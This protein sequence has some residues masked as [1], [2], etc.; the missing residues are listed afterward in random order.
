MRSPENRPQKVPQRLFAAFL[1]A[2]A[3]GAAAYTLAGTIYECNR[4][5]DRVETPRS[6][7][8][9]PIPGFPKQQ[10]TK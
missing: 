1:T 7:P 9:P 5:L 4:L 10:N 8:L 2:A 6:Q 3:V